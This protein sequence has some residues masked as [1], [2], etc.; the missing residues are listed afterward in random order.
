MN[1]QIDHALTTIRCTLDGM[2]AIFQMMMEVES[3][4]KDAIGYLML[5]CVSDIRKHCDVIEAETNVDSVTTD[6]QRI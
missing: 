2:E 4:N 3:A 1:H 5:S 6:I